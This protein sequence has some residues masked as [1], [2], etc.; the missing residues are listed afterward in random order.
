MSSRVQ[1]TLE[2]HFSKLLQKN[3]SQETWV[4]ALKAR[5]SKIAID[6]LTLEEPQKQVPREYRDVAVISLGHKW[7]CV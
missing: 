5:E 4:Q 6:E 1:V 2:T 7:T 3:K